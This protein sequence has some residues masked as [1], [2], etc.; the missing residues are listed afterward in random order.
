MPL[1]HAKPENVGISTDVSSTHARIAKNFSDLPNSDFNQ[2]WRLSISLDQVGLVN[3]L[4]SLC[5]ALIVVHVC[6]NG[7]SCVGH[8]RSVTH[9]PVV[10][11]VICGVDCPRDMCFIA[12]HPS[13]FQSWIAKNCASMC[14]DLPV[15]FFALMISITDQL[16][17]H[18]GAGPFSDI[19]NSNNEDLMH[20]VVLAA[21]TA[22]VDSILVELSAVFN[23][24]LDWCSAA[25][26]QCVMAR[27]VVDLLF[28]GLFP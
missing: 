13:S 26:L 16:S 22:A 20:N 3:H 19:P 10:G 14:L 9:I 15:R 28:A 17:L 6:D 8:V 7:P 12:V 23:C 2:F 11:Q 1:S 21:A 27:P 4:A 5:C 25:P 18:A 24:A